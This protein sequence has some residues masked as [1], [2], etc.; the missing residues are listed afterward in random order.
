MPRITR[1]SFIGIGIVTFALGLTTVMAC[2][3][4]TEPDLPPT[5]PVPPNGNAMII[6]E[7]TFGEKGSNTSMAG[8]VDDGQGGFFFHGQL[9][10]KTVVGRL[11]SQGEIL[12]TGDGV[13]RF[14]SIARVPVSGGSAGNA[15]LVVGGDDLDNNGSPDVAVA[16]LYDGNGIVTDRL[17][18]QHDNGRTWFRSLAV[19]SVGGNQFEC[20]AV[21][22]GNITSVED[23]YI[24]RFSIAGDTLARGNEAVFTDL[25][26]MILSDVAFGD[27]SPSQMFYVAGTDF[28]SNAIRKNAFVIQLSELLEIQWFRNLVT[29]GIQKTGAHEVI[30]AGGKAY[31]GGDA[32]KEK[33][34]YLWTVG[35]LASVSTG[36]ATNWVQVGAPSDYSDL[37]TDCFFKDGY[38]YIVGGYGRFI[39][40]QSRLLFGYALLSKVDPVT[41]D[42]ISNHTFGSAAHR[43]GFNDVI[44]SDGTAYCVGFKRYE[45][46][47]FGYQGWFAQV[48]TLGS[49]GVAPEGDAQTHND[50][51]PSLF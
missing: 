37:Y 35:F 18:F 41:G 26:G 5:H 40:I 50:Y 22:G 45:Q 38:L 44:V 29:A 14:T 6:N 47:G 7:R 15:L 3:N 25:A 17:E 51:L 31:V 32:L 30:F 36:G 12:W 9:N 10:S 11:D 34:G 27:N 49:S 24:A 48:D 39:E 43:S 28:D 20:V 2:S 42:V 16:L 8:I 13:S 21:G 46:S 1:H 23:P 19:A 4:S 33:R